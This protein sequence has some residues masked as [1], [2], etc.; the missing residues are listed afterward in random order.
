MVRA[1]Q[2]SRPKS[3]VTAALEDVFVGSRTA[4]SCEPARP[5]RRHKKGT[6]SLCPP[7]KQTNRATARSPGTTGTP[8]FILRPVRSIGVDLASGPGVFICGDC[9]RLAI[10]I[11]NHS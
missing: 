3:S 5:L 10:E 11:T 1:A 9:A 6:R 7:Q 2:P 4:S 8:L